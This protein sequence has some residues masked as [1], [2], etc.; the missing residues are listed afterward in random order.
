MPSGHFVTLYVARKYPGTELCSL[1]ANKT[2]PGLYHF[3]ASQR[4]VV[5]ACMRLVKPSV[6]ETTPISFRLD[7]W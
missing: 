4:P 2:D 5:W 7:L 6:P 1:E 3:A